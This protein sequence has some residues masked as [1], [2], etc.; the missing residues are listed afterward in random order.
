MLNQIPV[1]TPV[2]IRIKVLII[3]DDPADRE[4]FK[5]YLVG[6]QP[7][8][9]PD[10]FIFAEEAAG[11]AGIARIPLFLPDCILLDYSLPDLDGLEVIRRLKGSRANSTSVAVVMLTAIGNEQ[12]AV[13]AMKLG[14]MDY[15]VKGTAGSEALPR[16]VINAI[17]RFRLEREIAQRNAALETMR[18]ELFEEKERYRTL[19]EAIPQLVWTADSSCRVEYANRRLRDFSGQT[20]EVWP[21]P[22]LVHEEDRPAFEQQWTQAQNTVDTFVAEVRLKRHDGVYRWHL[23]RAVP[24]RVSET[25]AV[26]WFGT[27]TDIEDQKRAEEALRQSQKLES[28]GVLAGGIAHD[29]NN[30][31][32]GIMGG[33]SFVA[34][35]LGPGSARSM[36]E[37]VVRSSE[38]AAH[39]VQ[40]LLAYAGRGVASIEAVDLGRIALDT[41]EL[42]SA[43]FTH[44]I[45]ITASAAQ[46]LPMVRGN[47]AQM[48]QIVLNLV[49]NAAEAIGE[50]NGRISIRIVPENIGPV[51]TGKN[52]LGY[53]LKPGD[54]VLLEVS[55]T[56]TGMDDAT[57]ARIFDPFF[58]TK[59]TGRGLGLAAMQGIVRTMEGAI[60][61]TSAPGEGSTFRVLL[62]AMTGQIAQAAAVSVASAQA[63]GK[64]RRRR[65]ILLIDDEE[66]VRSTTAAALK[67]QGYDV[68]AAASGAE[69]VE[70][71]R[72]QRD[73]I[74]LILLDLGMPGMQGDQ[75]LAK[76]R[77]ISPS[78]TVAIMS[79]YAEQDIASRF[80]GLD[81][82]RFIAKPFSARTVAAT[83]AGII[84]GKS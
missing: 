23:V 57:Q 13:K 20:D 77:A 78:V 47:V 41:A 10:T 62:P 84:A 19:T 33:A 16:T 7:G 17:Q 39:L 55:D 38:R 37:V 34:D 30:L 53:A 35:T 52:I 44:K 45:I 31:L 59:F 48:Q 3:D 70:R 66:A 51:D 49:V 61:L 72:E 2:P 50:E 58:T 12:I 15:V 40:Q 80:A 75:V 11:A 27:L 74:S 42:V 54:Y 79:G 73:T 69:G 21:L 28:I 56:G 8:D 65:L 83:V 76:L 5:S 82:A 71:F 25:E 67:E 22:S 43:S 1:N 60:Q 63:S 81:V 9:Q 64:A 24:N 14:V 26:K 46:N 68:V 4:I 32:T 6:D 18:A 29:F 36:L